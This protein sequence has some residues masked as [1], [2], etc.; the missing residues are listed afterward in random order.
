MFDVPVD[1]WYVW[2]GLSIA[3][4]TTFGIAAAVPATPPPDA[5]GATETIDN[6]AASQYA[7]VGEHPMSNADELRIAGDVV[8]LRG[9]GGTVDETLLYGPV[10]PAHEG[11][12]AAIR[13]GTP[14]ESVFDSPVAF[15]Q[16][17][18]AAITAE[19]EY[20][21]TDRIVVRRVSWGGVDVTLV[22]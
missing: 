9:P 20:H 21:R 6:V 1:A 8:S 10:A 14:P 11:D 22:G 13:R 5:A 19:A 4:A 15:K 2:V 12:L 7:A 3:S 18:E 17:I 16:A